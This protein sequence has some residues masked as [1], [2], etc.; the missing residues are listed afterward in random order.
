MTLFC[1][2]PSTT[3][4]LNLNDIVITKIKDTQDTVWDN[5]FHRYSTEMNR[6]QIDDDFN[7][8]QVSILWNFLIQNDYINEMKYNYNILYDL[9]RYIYTFDT[10]VSHDE[11]TKIGFA[12]G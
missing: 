11:I 2:L 10:D 6:F 7:K 3:Y 9:A 5:L 12:L 4:N 8:N 1:G